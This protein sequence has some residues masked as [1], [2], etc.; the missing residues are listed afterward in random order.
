M[1][2]GLNIPRTDTGRYDDVLRVAQHLGGKDHGSATN[3]VAVMVR[4]SKLFKVT[5]EMLRAKDDGDGKG[6]G[7]VPR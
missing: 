6:E 2:T 1:L 7:A 4:Q 3:A 5:L